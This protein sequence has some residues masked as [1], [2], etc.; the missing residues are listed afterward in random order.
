MYPAVD[1]TPDSVVFE[2]FQLCLYL[3]F[4]VMYH[5]FLHNSSI[6]TVC[7]EEGEERERVA[8][9]KIHKGV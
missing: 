8:M 5:T 2:H 7:R 6:F 9:N 4:V 3:Y 1:A